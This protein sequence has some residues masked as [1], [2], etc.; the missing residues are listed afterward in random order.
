[1]A[2]VVKTPKDGA[3]VL[4]TWNLTTADATGDAISV[5]GASDRSVQF[6][7]TNWGGAT[8]LLEWSLDG[9]NYVT[10]TDGQG[11]AVSFTD[12][13]GEMISENA[14]LFRPRLS[15]GGTAA[16][17]EALLLSRSTMR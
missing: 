8:A 3:V 14:L 7:G 11:T 4:H 12:D 16:V 5:P 17:I 10:A 6:F 9:T 1:M 13:G 15:V 2:S